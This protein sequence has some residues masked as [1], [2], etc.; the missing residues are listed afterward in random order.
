MAANVITVI[1]ITLNT[2][3]AIVGPTL[4]LEMARPTI[5]EIAYTKVTIRSKIAKTIFDPPYQANSEN[6]HLSL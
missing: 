5:V 3:A 6:L 2:N 4:L 1:A